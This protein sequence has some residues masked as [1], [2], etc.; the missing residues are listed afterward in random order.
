MNDNTLMTTMAEV[1]ERSKALRV[2]AQNQ[3]G[4]LD[5]LLRHTKVERSLINRLDHVCRL[6]DNIQDTVN[7]IELDMGTLDNLKLK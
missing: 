6:V 2:E 4:Y 5:T 1:M 3:K 7:R